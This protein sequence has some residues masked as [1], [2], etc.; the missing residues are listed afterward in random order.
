MTLVVSVHD[1]TP[2]HGE[3][4]LRLLDILD[5]LGVERGALLAVPRWHGAWPLEEDRVLADRLRERAAAGWEVVL[6]G[7]RHDEVGVRRSPGAALRAAGRT[8][9]EAEFLSLD[10]GEAGRR[11]DRGLEVLWS[12]GLDPAGFV[13]PA[14][15][16]AP[17]LDGVVRAR[18]LEVTEDV[19]ELR[20]AG[21]A[22]R[23]RAPVV[24]WSTR[25]ALRRAAGRAHAALWRLRPPRAPV[26]RV[27]LHPPDV[28]H[29]RILRS[30]E[31]T[32]GALLVER[33]PATCREALAAA[34]PA[35]AS[36]P[37]TGARRAGG[38]RAA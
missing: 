20:E 32:L 16:A 8:A 3:R 4:V 19:R 24:T 11:V 23:L 14:W 18:G 31:A 30:A 27:A 13:A 34:A 37:L 7:W 15:L 33:E 28:D 12:V 29:P 21:G 9:G 38:R 1:V 25:T 10:P 36:S 26:V 6:H 17:G 2:A 35:E 22:R 5:R